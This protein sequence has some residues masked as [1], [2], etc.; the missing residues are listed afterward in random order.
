MSVAVPALVSIHDVMPD[1]LDRI[2]Q[3]I[4]QELTNIDPALVVLLVVPGLEWSDPQKRRLRA[5]QDQGYELAGH[6]WLHRI[7]R[8]TSPYHWLHSVTISRRAAEHLSLTSAELVGLV[9]DNF[10]WFASNDLK[11]PEY[12]VPPA[13]ALGKLSGDALSALPYPV[14][15]VT[16]GLLETATGKIEALPLVGFEADTR[17]RATFLSRWN[18][19]NYSRA[20]AERPVRLSI[21]PFDFD[22][23][24]AQQLRDMIRQCQAV[25]W[26]A[27]LSPVKLRQAA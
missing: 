13:W 1:T 2:E 20:S 6:G 25:N 18:H 7:H 26:R 21:H 3:I 22:F 16:R 8:F 23:L 27:V 9:N 24:I 19:F 11:Q 14:I 17:F 10:N 4:S 15:E 5:L 12:Y